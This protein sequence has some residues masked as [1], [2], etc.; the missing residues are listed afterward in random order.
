MARYLSIRLFA[1]LFAFSLL[2]SYGLA[3]HISSEM[4]FAF[5]IRPE[6]AATLATRIQ[7][8][9]A[10]GLG[11][12]VLLMF[13]V[14]FAGSRA[15]RSALAQRWL[16]GAVTSIAFL[17][18]AGLVDRLAEHDMA[19]IAISTFQLSIEAFAILLL[20]GEDASGWFAARR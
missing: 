5:P 15:S 2:L 16:L 17:R 4:T 12:A 20:Y 1:L 8:I 9:R 14:I 10:I 7:A 6:A 13:L 18:G 3:R 11:L 19:L